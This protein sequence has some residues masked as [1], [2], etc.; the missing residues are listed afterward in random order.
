M[1]KYHHEGYNLLIHTFFGLYQVALA[2]RLRYMYSS[3][4]A[5]LNTETY[6]RSHRGLTERC[7][8]CE[9]GCSVSDIAT[10][11]Q[12]LTQFDRQRDVSGSVSRG[13][14]T[15]TDS[16]RLYSW[17][18]WSNLTSLS[19]AARHRLRR[20]SGVPKFRPY[21]KCFLQSKLS[22]T[23]SLLPRRERGSV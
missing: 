10:G 2:L 18:H 21:R 16:T 9:Q 17:I 13:V 15:S 6:C 22:A 14:R 19:F 5:M 7:A 12:S 20:V 1:Y 3:P 23:P 8:A 4:G 11:R